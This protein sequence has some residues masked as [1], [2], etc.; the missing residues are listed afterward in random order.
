MNTKKYGILPN[1]Q[2]EKFFVLSLI[3][4]SLAILAGCWGSTTQKSKLVMINVLDPDYYQDCHIAGSI[5]IP[6]EQF[7]ERAKTLDKNDCYVLYCSNHA[8]T[9]APFCASFLK[10]AGFKDVSLLPGGIVEWYQKGYPCTG[11]ATKEY[12]KEVD[13]PLGDL[14]HPGVKE[15]SADDLKQAMIQEKL[16]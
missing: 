15:L 5:N 3:V 2:S 7:E 10:D 1:V 13:E 9:A 11:N 14:D 8:C 16:I 12:L 6:F 4:C